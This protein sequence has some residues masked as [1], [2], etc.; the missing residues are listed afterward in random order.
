MS[1]VD[2][3]V[4]AGLALMFPAMLWV[5]VRLMRRGLGCDTE[6]EYYSRQDKKKPA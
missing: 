4:R 2:M 6:E 5:V 3:I 1:E